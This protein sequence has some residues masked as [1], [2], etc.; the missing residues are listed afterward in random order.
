MTVAV[1]VISHPPLAIGKCGMKGINIKH[2]SY[3]L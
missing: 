2:I 1:S 3:H